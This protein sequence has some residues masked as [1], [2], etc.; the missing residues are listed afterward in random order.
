MELKQKVMRHF[1][2][3]D[4]SQTI[5]N[6]IL[7]LTLVGV[8]QK[9]HAA[10]VCCVRAKQPGKDTSGTNYRK[11]Y[12]SSCQLWLH[13]LQSILSFLLLPTGVEKTFAFVIEIKSPFNGLRIPTTEKITILLCSYSQTVYV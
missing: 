11:S 2:H 6:L 8:P 5:G 9:Q 4:Y 7:V 12:L 3:V 10:A 13:L 1:N